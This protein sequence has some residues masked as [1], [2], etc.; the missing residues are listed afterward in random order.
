MVFYV[1][2]KLFS[3]SL[4]DDPGP[5]NV[6]KEGK[7]ISQISKDPRRDEWLDLED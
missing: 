3:E 5:G 6:D 1:T 4:G 7:L 2:K